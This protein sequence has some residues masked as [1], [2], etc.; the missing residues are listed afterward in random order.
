M[1]LLTVAAQLAR[2]PHVSVSLLTVTRDAK[3]ISP[4]PRLMVTCV[5]PTPEN[6]G[7]LGFLRRKLH[8]LSYYR[9]ML[10]ELLQSRATV[11]FSKLASDEA[12]LSFVA[13]RLRRKPWCFRIEHD[14]ETDPEATRTHIFAGS[15]MR[16]VL[17][18][19]CLRRADLVIAQTPKQQNALR[20]QLSITSLL[21][22]NAHHVESLPSPDPGSRKGLL[23]IARA[24]AMK[25]PHLYVRLAKELSHFPAVLIMPPSP[26]HPG[27]SA[28]LNLLVQQISNLVFLPGVPPS[29][30]PDYYRQAR[31]FVLTSDAEGF[32]NTIIE[33]MKNGTP[34]ISLTLDFD[35]ALV[36]VPN[37][38]GTLTPAAGFCAGDDFQLFV[39]IAV[40]LLSDDRFW[41]ECSREAHKYARTHFDV[42]A[43]A[44]RYVKALN[45]LQ[46][47][48]PSAG[49]RKQSDQ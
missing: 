11:Y 10:A 23:W 49:R 44:P 48:R 25:R 45:G 47:S 3:L 27:V 31:L 33:A 30:L 39:S 37:E 36:P 46:S 29:L 35:G 26:E 5:R 42:S 13:S 8:V 28:E 32:A 9:R 16:T 7:N 43:I 14:W 4:E 40:R 21:I 12:I 24:H 38:P 6:M 41:E 20:D 17:F 22:P 15:R 18:H 19:E 2:E 1:E 34:V